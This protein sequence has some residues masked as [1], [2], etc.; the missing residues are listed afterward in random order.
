[1]DMFHQD[2]DVISGFPLI[3]EEP[4]ANEEQTYYELVRSFMSDGRIYLRQLNLLILVFREPF[5]S[6]PM[7][8]SHHV[9]TCTCPI[10]AVLHRSEQL[11]D[12][13]PDVCTRTWTVS[14]VGLLIS[15][16]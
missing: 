5:A 2:E 16:R 3:D 13:H 15:T 9:R 8:F 7:L 12:S 6:S 14:S 10:S 1:M 4:L 11:G